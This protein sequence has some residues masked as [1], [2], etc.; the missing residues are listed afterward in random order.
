MKFKFTILLL[1]PF[2]CITLSAQKTATL[3]Y[4]DQY[5]DIAIKEM[6]RT[7]IPASITLAQG[8]V[9]SNS[10]ESNLALNFNNHFGIKCKSDWKGLSTYQDDDTKQECFRV[11]PNANASFIDHSNFIKTRPNYAPLFQLDPVDDS[12]W[13]IGLKKAGYATAS[14]YAFKLMKVIDD[15][16]LSQ[17]NFPELND[18]NDTAETETTTVTEKPMV[19]AKEVVAKNTSLDKKETGSNSSMEA[20]KETGLRMPV[21]KDTTIQVK[22]VKD[23]ASNYINQ[24]SLPINNIKGIES[25]KTIATV[26]EIK[27]NS[28]GNDTT[29]VTKP[30]TNAA[31]TEIKMSS[32]GKDTAIAKKTNTPVKDTI[33]KK[34]SSIYPE[35]PFKINQV[36][37]IWA[38][39]GTS[40]LQI[41]TENNIPLYKVFVF[42]DLK[43][44]DLLAEDQLL[45]LANKKAEADKSFHLVVTGESL[46]NISQKEGIQLKKL[47][48]YNPGISDNPAAGTQLILVKPKEQKPKLSLKK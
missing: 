25:S 46:Y 26:T 10:G 5:K 43:E 34:P 28:I 47:K 20:P 24:A 39:A 31:V 17:F 36:S 4:I 42:N 33:S 2:F 8:I 3:I 7:G 16:E 6:K 37:V 41:A 23:S 32:N 45:F 12:A 40:L 1:L 48:E 9:E 13:A 35:K 29:I 15:Y 11:Y 18:E 21:N 38:K 22:A 30:K 14:D 44:T 19:V 27:M